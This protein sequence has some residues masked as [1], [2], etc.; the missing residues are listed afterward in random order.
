MAGAARRPHR[1][2]Q[3]AASKWLPWRRACRTSALVLPTTG[4]SIPAESPFW[5]LQTVTV[6]GVS[7]VLLRSCSFI[8]LNYHSFRPNLAYASPNP[9]LETRDACQ[10]EP[11]HSQDTP[12]PGL[13]IPSGVQ[14]KMVS[15]LCSTHPPLWSRRVSYSLGWI[16]IELPPSSALE[17]MGRKVIGRERSIPYRIRGSVDDVFLLPQ[18]RQ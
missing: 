14:D 10:Y 13:S 9:H 15:C 17:T 6:C 18:E 2:L 7:A 1:I 5:P 8:R 12:S 11:R 3:P 16:F 4:R